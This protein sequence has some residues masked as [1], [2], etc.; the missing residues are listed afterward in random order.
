M[1]IANYQQRHEGVEGTAALAHC[2]GEANGRPPWNA[3]WESPEKLNPEFP[4]DPLPRMHP[5][6]M[7]TLIATQQLL[8]GAHSSP[9]HICLGGD[10]LSVIDG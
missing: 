4:Q 1:D 6:G 7:K 3:A 2:W 8:Q 10:S 9:V 5:A